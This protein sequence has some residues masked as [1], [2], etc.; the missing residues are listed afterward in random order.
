MNIL[1]KIA[2]FFKTQT[3]TSPVTPESQE[4][5]SM[6]VSGELK[7]FLENEV[8]DGLDISPEHFWSSLE[9][10]LAEFGPRNKALLDK[11]EVIQSQI[12]QWHLARKNTDHDHEEYK[13]F[14][15]EIGYIVSDTGDFKISTS[16]VDNEIKTIAG[17]QLVVPVMNARFA[18]NAANA[19]WGSLYDALYGTDVISEDDGATKAGAYNPVRGDKVIAFAKD[20]LNSTIPLDNGSFADVNGFD[21][22][23][24]DS[25]NVIE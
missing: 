12:D 5:Q 15:K 4:P 24:E 11:R 21:F 2:S 18:L 22:S 3:D 1:N 20:F 25:F 16:D 19:R 8:V 7:S 14:L 6:R 23:D 10:I 9:S 13:D 17:P